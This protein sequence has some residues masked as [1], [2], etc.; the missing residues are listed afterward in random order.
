MSHLV[1]EKKDDQFMSINLS[2]L[3]KSKNNLDQVILVKQVANRFLD[4]P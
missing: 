4:H 2:D 3:M 1:I